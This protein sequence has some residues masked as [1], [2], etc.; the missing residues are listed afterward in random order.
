MP[1][2]T[3]EKELELIAIA[4]AGMRAELSKE[5]P[6]FNRLEA[7]ADG[8]EARNELIVTNKAFIYDRTTKELRILKKRNQA[9]QWIGYG[10]TAY[11]KAIEKFDAKFG[12]RLNTYSSW[13]IKCHVRRAACGAR[14]TPRYRFESTLTSLRGF[15]DKIVAAPEDDNFE[16]EQTAHIVEMMNVALSLLKPRS[17]DVLRQR[18]K[19]RTL[20]EIGDE[21]GL[22]K[23]RIRQ[24]EARAHQDL[25]NFYIVK[26]L[27]A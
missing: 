15:A 1:Y 22:S 27:V 11:L 4:Q 19:G 10:V 25:K 3:R 26:Q 13:W 6:T 5:G 21:M 16:A 9:D 14:H 12:C 18:M 8:I 20:E 7:I 24:I 23:E 2:H 17:A